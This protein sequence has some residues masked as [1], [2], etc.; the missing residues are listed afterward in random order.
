M[1]NWVEA[2]TAPRIGYLVRWSTKGQSGN[3]R[4]KEQ[5]ETLPELLRSRGFAPVLFREGAKSGHDMANRD[6]A[7]QLLAAIEDEQLDGLGAWDVKRITRDDSGM[8]AGRIIRLCKAKR[9]IIVTA[10]R[11]YRV[12]QRQDLKEFKR[13]A[14]EAGEDW[15]NIR[16]TFWQ[17]IIGRAKREPFF[18]GVT[19]VGYRKELIETQPGEDGERSRVKRLPAKDEAQAEMMAK[20]GE[21]LDECVTLGE[22]VKRMNEGA[23][24][25]KAYRGR[26]R[27][28]PVPWQIDRL[29]GV[30]FNPLYVGRWEFGRHADE[31]SPIWD[32][33]NV[34]ADNNGKVMVSLD[35]PDL[36]WYDEARQRAWQKKYKDSRSSRRFRTRDYHRPLRG[37]LACASCGEIM[38]SRGAPGY[39][40]PHSN[41]SSRFSGCAK[42]QTLSEK[43]AFNELWKLLPTLLQERA[44]WKEQLRSTL[45]GQG[46]SKTKRAE[47]DQLKALL[48]DSVDSWFDGKGP[49]KVPA[50]LQRKWEEWQAQI[51]IREAELAQME[52]AE[53]TDDRMERLYALIIADPARARRNMTEDQQA[54]FFRDIVADVQL[55]PH[56]WAASR[57]FTVKSYTN[58]MV[59]R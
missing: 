5:D 43:M 26:L 22:V 51:D 4:G 10:D 15:L 2:L 7:L 57:S 31:D 50:P 40:C 8:D 3:Y 13:E 20:L 27:G 28:K 45:A 56:G 42:P 19:P 44:D 47:L 39:T 12:W 16:D 37:I 34:P 14:F 24:Y 41:V 52:A 18:I 21:A 53:L 32:L 9:A 49:R 58:L 11:E 1:R 23:L 30:L 6:V 25:P 29:E 36:A 46:K 38:V 55:E 17:G 59:R 35:R 48:Q 54:A 33:P